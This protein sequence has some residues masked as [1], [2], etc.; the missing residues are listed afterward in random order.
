MLYLLIRAVF[1][2]TVGKIIFFCAN[3]CFILFLDRKLSV[4]LFNRAINLLHIVGTA[5]EINTELIDDSYLY[6]V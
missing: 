2:I 5:A 3:L 6:T 1:F 4:S